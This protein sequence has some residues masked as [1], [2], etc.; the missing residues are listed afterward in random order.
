VEEEIMT[1][2]EVA[3]YLRLAEAT[4]YK[5]ARD[6]NIPAMKLGR[7]WRFKRDLID[8]WFRYETMQNSIETEDFS[9]HCSVTA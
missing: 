7:A 3:E 8:E 9:G 1:T 6:G 2:K 4:V 5:L